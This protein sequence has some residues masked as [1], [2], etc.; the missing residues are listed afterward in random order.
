MEDKNIFI[1]IIIPCR[2]EERFIGKC[3]ES[4]LAQDY[5][6]EQLE[7]IIADGMSTDKTRE[8]LSNYAD[9]YNFIQC[10]D[11]PKKLAAAALNLMIPKAKGEIIIRMD[12]HNIYFKDYVSKS[13][14]YLYECKA[15]N[16]G[17][18]WVT[19]PGAETITAKAIALALSS[20]F[21]IG[22]ALFRTGTKKPVYTDTVPFGCYKREIFDKIG[23]FDEEAWRNED[24]EFNLRL[25]KNGGKILLAPDIVSYYYARE[26]FGKL[27]NMYYQYGYFKPQS[28][29]KLKGIF[30]L[31]QLV[32]AMLTASLMILFL[33][34]FFNKYFFLL[35]F[36]EAVIYF[37][38]NF[39]VSFFIAIK[40][41]STLLPFLMIAFMAVHFSYGI[42]YLKGISDFI[43]LK[44]KIK[45]VPITR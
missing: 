7:I 21:G 13:M 19:L 9:K 4:I 45:D 16:V 40:N 42:G 6:R 26:T 2:N 14:R 8:I 3:L 36:V 11:N 25:I 12:A 34:G 24:D 10:F 39:V 15:D 1:S 23:F 22:N 20:N 32:P 44:K 5:P 41:K 30:T 38:I 33:A 35:F 43:V 28:V 27:W 37:F 29:M 31:R 18:I 17:G